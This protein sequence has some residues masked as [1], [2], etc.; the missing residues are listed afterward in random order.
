MTLASTLQLTLYLIIV[1]YILYLLISNN[2]EPS[3]LITNNESIKKTTVKYLPSYYAKSKAPK[4]N[5]PLI[6][7][8]L[9]VG[10]HSYKNKY[11]N[12]NKDNLKTV[13]KSLSSYYVAIKKPEGSDLLIPILLPETVCSYKSKHINT[14]NK[15]NRKDGT[16]FHI[17]AIKR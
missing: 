16:L 3:F 17:Y 6:F 8:F 5:N 7:G 14:K 13:I 15:N 11:I 2:K 12:R 10:A 9:I 1:K 4:D